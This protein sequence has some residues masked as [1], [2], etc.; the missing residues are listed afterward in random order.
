MMEIE[1][2]MYFFPKLTNKPSCGT[3]SSGVIDLTKNPSDLVQDM[4]KPVVKPS[5]DTNDISM[6]NNPS[7]SEVSIKAST[8]ETS[9]GHLTVCNKKIPFA[10]PDV[11]AIARQ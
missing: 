3:S 9:S 8:F 10:I 6:S 11:H 4:S 7:G 2:M 5:I 1:L